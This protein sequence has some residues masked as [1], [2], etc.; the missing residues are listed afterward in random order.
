MKHATKTYINSIY[1]SGLKLRMGKIPSDGD[2]ARQL[3]FFNIRDQRATLAMFF[4]G[5]S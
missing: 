4:L 5:C 3:F 1:F 2:A